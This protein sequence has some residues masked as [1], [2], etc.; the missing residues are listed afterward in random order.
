M[1]FFIEETKIVGE[2]K[3]EPL[4]CIVCMLP[5]EEGQKKIFCPYCGTPAH[6]EHFLEWIKIKGFCPM[7]KRK[8]PYSISDV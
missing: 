2:W 5:I 1:R 8:I 6:R 4:K 7:C 3:W